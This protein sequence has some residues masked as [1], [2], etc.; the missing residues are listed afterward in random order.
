MMIDVAMFELFREEVKTHADTLGN[1]LVELDARPADGDLLSELMRAAHSI[2]GAARIVGIDTAVQLAH[3]LEDAL[4]AAQE[5]K[6][7]L[8][9][10]DI[11]VLLRASDVLAG[12][13]ALSPDAVA[14]WEGENAP[15]VA[16]L[17]PLL[18]A[19]AEGR[20][21]PPAPSTEGREEVSPSP[22][23]VPPSGL[24]A[25]A[26]GGTH[27]GEGEKPAPLPS[28]GGAGGASVGAAPFPA[29]P[30][31]APAAIPADPLPLG[32]GHSM[33]DLFREE[34]RDHLRAVATA[35]PHLATDPTA[36]EPVAERLKQL[37]GAARLVKCAP[38]GDAAG[39]IGTYLR[40]TTETQTPL[41]DG[42]VGWL[43]YA[44]GVL[45]G[46][47][48]TDDDTFPD[49]V[50]QARPALE[51]VAAAFAR[52]AEGLRLAAKSAANSPPPAPPVTTPPKSVPVSP[53]APPKDEAKPPARADAPRAVAP[54]TAPLVTQV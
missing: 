44:T 23:W 43:K 52:A 35:V 12:L 29:L 40:A 13:S 42:A 11:D 2:K 5:G 4:V 30:A 1:G 27:R 34:A 6:A 54:P 14:R 25:D 39:A 8:T 28:G 16:A 49:W 32:A 24:Q 17:E 45:A 9:A 26:V 20:P 37:R 7:K 48:Q 38:V 31:F 47:I 53:P 3:V 22:L 18:V 19:V 51:A 41:P 15:A 33:L 46:A 21:A 36:V 10:A 50:A